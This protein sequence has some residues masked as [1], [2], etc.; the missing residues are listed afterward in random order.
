MHRR[1]FRLASG[2]GAAWR[3]GGQS[4]WS[5]APAAVDNRATSPDRRRRI[6]QGEASGHRKKTSKGSVR[7]FGGAA[8]SDVRVRVSWTLNWRWS[9]LRHDLAAAPLVPAASRA[10]LLLPQ[11]RRRRRLAGDDAARPMTFAVLVED[12]S[13]RYGRQG[14]AVQAL[15]GVSLEVAP[16]SIYGLLGRNGAGKTTLVK[17][18][19][20]IVRPTSGR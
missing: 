16:G 7:P 1:P 8:G 20:D 15:A 13:K 14:R 4:G 2:S 19:L 9:S 11:M 17:I 5:V 6:E 3:G 18:L 10:A 12:V